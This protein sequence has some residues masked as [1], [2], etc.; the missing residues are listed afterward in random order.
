MILKEQDE[1]MIELLANGHPVAEVAVSLGCG[2]AT[3]YRR[4]RNPDVRLRLAAARAAQ[5][6]PQ[7][8]RLRTA[9]D[10]A[11]AE[12]ERLSTEAEHESTRLRACTAIVQFALDLQKTA[13]F[14][15]RLAA[16]ETQLA[17]YTQP[18]EIR[19]EE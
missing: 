19:D 7:A 2:V 1:R 15:E 11:I 4:L 5:W 9:C 10:A 12:I 3:V 8:N 17:E 14:N 13:A 18:Q 16:V 6:A